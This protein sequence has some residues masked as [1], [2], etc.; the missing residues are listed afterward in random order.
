MSLVP[1]WPEHEA[2]G[3]YGAFIPSRE[4]RATWRTRV[5]GHEAKRREIGQA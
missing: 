2:L 1:D 5:T 3:L 4:D